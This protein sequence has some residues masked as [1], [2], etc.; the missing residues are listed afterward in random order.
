M[1]ME[2]REQGKA[3]KEGKNRSAERECAELK[4]KGRNSKAAERVDHERWQKR[5]KGDIV[6]CEL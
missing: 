6:Y 3:C 5:T 1:R 2:E 4:R